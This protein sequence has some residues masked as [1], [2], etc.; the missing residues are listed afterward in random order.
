M[1]LRTVYT[2]AII[3]ALAIGAVVA[4]APAHAFAAS[5]PRSEWQCDPP[6]LDPEKIA[7]GREQKRECLALEDPN[8]PDSIIGNRWE[9]RCSLRENNQYLCSIWDIR[10]SGNFETKVGYVP[11]EDT[12]EW[13]PVEHVPTINGAQI[14]MRKDGLVENFARAAGG[15]LGAAGNLLGGIGIEIIAGLFALIS[16]VFVALGQLLLSII[17]YILD[18]VVVEFVVEMGKYITAPEA[19]AVRVAWVLFRDLANIGIIAG[20]VA[21]AIGTIVG[22]GSYNISKTLAR[23]ILAALLVNFSYFIT[24]AI[25]DASNFVA[26]AAYEHVI[27]DRSHCGIAERFVKTLNGGGANSTAIT[28]NP[29]AIEQQITAEGALPFARPTTAM[30]YNIMAVIFMGM[31]MFVFLAVIS[32][33]IG[34]FVA[35]IFLLVTSPIGIAGMAVPILKNY[36]DEW[37]KAL[38]SQTM[39]A[40]VYF[41]LVGISLNIFAQLED[42]IRAQPA[43]SPLLTDSVEGMVGTVALFVVGIGFMLTA[44]T[45][46]KKMSAEAERFKQL[47]D[48]VQKYV[49]GFAARETMGRAAFVFGQHYPGFASRL[50]ESRL[51]KALA[52]IPGV[53][54]LGRSA[55]RLIQKTVT[56]VGEQKFGGLDGY[57][58]IFDAKLARKAELAEKKK[59]LENKDQDDG[60]EARANLSKREKE[61]KKKK[62]E[63]AQELAQLEKAEKDGS[64]SALGRDRLKELRDERKEL[65]DIK[66]FKKRL[67]DRR[68]ALKNVSGI[69]KVGDEKV[70][71]ADLAKLHEER[72]K[73]L[74]KGPREKLSASDKSTL[75]SLEE[76]I[77]DEE[78]FERLKD[79]FAW[80]GAQGMVRRAKSKHGR[81]LKAGERLEDFNE[82]ARSEHLENRNGELDS[83]DAKEL[84]DLENE[85]AKD[86]NN[87]NTDP[88][89]AA[90]KARLEALEKQAYMNKSE[91][92]AYVT[93]LQK[94]RGKTWDQLSADE[95]KALREHLTDDEVQALQSKKLANFERE[96]RDNFRKRATPLSGDETK[97]LTDLRAKRKA[98]TLT[99]HK[100]IARLAELEERDAVQKQGGLSKATTENLYS[101]R[102][103]Q[104]TREDGLGRDVLTKVNAKT[105]ERYLEA[106][107]LSAYRYRAETSEKTGYRAARG[108]RERVIA[109]FSDEYLQKEYEKNPNNIVKYATALSSDQWLKLAG[110]HKISEEIRN[111]MWAERMG[112]YG[113]GV[114]D[115][116]NDIKSGKL[117]KGSAEHRERELDLYNWVTRYVPNKEF[118]EALKQ[119]AVIGHD[120]NGEHVRLKDLNAGE[121]RGTTWNTSS[122]TA[123]ADAKDSKEYG[124]NQT[125]EIAKS[126]RAKIDRIRDLEAAGYMMNGLADS[127]RFLTNVAGTVQYD[128]KARAI[129]SARSL[130]A[131]S[132][133]A[134][135]RYNDPETR[136]TMTVDDYTEA[137]RNRRFAELHEES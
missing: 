12:V 87:F 70:E 82:Q 104:K 117:K 49:T 115:I 27:C 68:F 34:R 39:F 19:T 6:E 107:D 48:G 76:K 17:G 37:W 92:A 112:F 78:E 94:S 13:D 36:S 114:V 118:I 4:V 16:S 102:S 103:R 11:G 119:D 69:T 42:T 52:K 116:H 123:F 64:I 67:W 60:T 84:R 80:G 73:I 32:L 55:D 79:R 1:G 23:L 8:D 61:L 63:T 136:G 10:P 77:K 22:S 121:Y 5:I 100:Q 91:E 110:N 45:T 54:A 133:E 99:D 50:Q 137:V 98:G 44:Y 132:E 57:K 109:N 127:E 2:F 113:Q 14:E 129:K 89:Y 81:A 65:E 26:R 126:K 66:K 15:A 47:Y 75:A 86:P 30:T 62:K 72:R 71:G 101:F 43:R 130:R 93:A 56:G 128:A 35:L 124:T 74:A 59:D 25:I 3:L 111:K 31:A 125:T 18:Y 96:E 105:G 85:R 20:L 24:G 51:G 106:E 53:G 29:F 28:A 21:T 38:W 9:E 134:I 83:K 88:K 120:P 108:E 58:S 90:Q 40:P 95:Q 41:L 131:E 33:L 46:A 122:S 7:D 135:A 97:D